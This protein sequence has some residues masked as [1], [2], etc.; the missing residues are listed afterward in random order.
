MSATKEK[1]LRSA[2]RL[3]N[4]HGVASITLR[5]IAQD[6]GMSQGNLT[7]HFK[8]REDIIEALYYKL[9]ATMDAEL[10]ALYTQ[11]SDIALLF[12]LSY[13]SMK[14]F[15]GYKFLLV[16]IVAIMRTHPAVNEHYTMLQHYRK[17]QFLALFMRMVEHN[18]LRAGETEGE[19]ERLYERMTILG[20]FWIA[21]A[22]MTQ[23]PS[24]NEETLRHYHFLL[25]DAIYPYLTKKGKK[26]YKQR[27]VEYG[28]STKH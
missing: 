5:T 10:Q 19:Y 7:Y 15:Y 16:D 9:V 13:H 21:T 8:K 2:L 20:D 4:E 27:L 18:V 11:A 28:Y 25:L 24:D 22:E 26:L 14:V 12:D 17:Q 6:V 1:I 23:P 3:F